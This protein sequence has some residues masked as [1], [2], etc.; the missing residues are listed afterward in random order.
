[1][2]EARGIL[3]DTNILAS[4]K[5]KILLSINEPLYITPTILL[6]YLDWAIESRNIWLGKGN[7]KRAK[8]YEKLIKLFPKLI[9]ELGINMIDQ[10]V[11]KDD[12]KEITILII[13]R[14]IDP[15]D[16]TNAITTKKQKLKTITQDK[17]WQRLQDYTKEI[18][19]I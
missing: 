19:F 5:L 6:E 1:M 18:I 2:E 11:D 9:E 14:N 15:G 7:E 13:Q 12:L 3:I 10:N 8:G 4:K 17:D 16:A